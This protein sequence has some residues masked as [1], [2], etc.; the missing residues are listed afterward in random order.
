MF[1]DETL[2]GTRPRTFG[3]LGEFRPILEQRSSYR[4]FQQGKPFW[5]VW[6]TGEY[7]FAPYKV[8]WKEMSGGGLWLRTSVQVNFVVVKNSYSRS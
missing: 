6:S 1:G 4:R 8:V 2:P 5:S 7:T 3:F